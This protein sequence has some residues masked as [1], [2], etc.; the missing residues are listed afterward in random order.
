MFMRPIT[1]NVSETVYRDYQNYARSL[2][3]PTAEL[4]REA[5]EAYWRERIRTRPSLRQH[6][7]SSVGKVKAPFFGEEDTLEE[8]LDV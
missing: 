1:I 3:R 7:P 5:M 8:M 4:I 6:S 2:D